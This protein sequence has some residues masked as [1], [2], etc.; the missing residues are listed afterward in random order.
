MES[1][2]QHLSSIV[3]NTETYFAN[4]EIGAII[5][6]LIPLICFIA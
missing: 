6:K 2:A 4:D 1:R 3:E 5:I